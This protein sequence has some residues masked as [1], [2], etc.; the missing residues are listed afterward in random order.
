MAGAL[1]IQPRSALPRLNTGILQYADR[2]EIQ[3]IAHLAREGRVQAG[4]AGEVRQVLE[5]RP[6]RSRLPKE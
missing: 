4:G 1:H 6:N 5:R 3:A 2:W